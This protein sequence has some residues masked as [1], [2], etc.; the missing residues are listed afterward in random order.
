MALARGGNTAGV[1]FADFVRL[2]RTAEPFGLSVGV[3]SGIL[4]QSV[5]F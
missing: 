1:L 3:A 5:R 2:F 4:R